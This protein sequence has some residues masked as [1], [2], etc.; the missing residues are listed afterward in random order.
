L[1]TVFGKSLPSLETNFRRV[2]ILTLLYCIPALQAMLPVNDPDIWW[3]LRTGQW[4]LAHGQLPTTDPFSTYGNGKL[5]VTYSWLFEVLVYSLYKNLGLSGILFFSVAM[6][7]LVGLSVHILIHQTKFPF[8]LEASFVAVTLV[9]MTPLMTPRPWLI[10]IVLFAVQLLILKHSEQTGKT[11][12]LLSL[13]VLYIIWANLHIQFIYGLVVIGF[14]TLESLI[15]TIVGR[16]LPSEKSQRVPAGSLLLVGSACILA[17]MVN[18]YGYNIYRQVVE[19]SLLTFQSVQELQP[20]SFVSPTDW[21]VIILVIGASFVLGSKRRLQPFSLLLL[22]LGCFLGF[23]ARRDVWVTLLAA[24]FIISEHLIVCCPS[25][26]FQLTCGRVLA[27]LGGITIAVGMIG[28]YRQLSE[29]HLRTAVEQRFPVKAVEFVRQNNYGGPLFNSFNWGGYLI[30]GLPQIPVSIDGRGNIHG[31]RVDRAYQTWMG[32]SGWD[33]DRELINS[34]IVIAEVSSPLASLLRMDSR[35]K[36][37]YE[38]G[39]AAVFV[40]NPAKS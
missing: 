21:I 5:W 32:Y 2:T 7:L 29:P 18:P 11:A 28:W 26:T 27:L 31:H 35:F 40:R 1:K 13:P 39:T 12:T 37:V 30:W 16:E 14:L 9:G 22:I 8:V 19:Y 23:R 15:L 25:D 33:S 10:S 36:V 3:H 38:D 24:A 17:T 4:I 34:R 6:S 20:L